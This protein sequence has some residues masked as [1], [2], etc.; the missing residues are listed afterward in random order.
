M[1]TSQSSRPDAS[2][3]PVPPPA[4][5]DSACHALSISTRAEVRALLTTSSIPSFNTARLAFP[6][7]HAVAL[8]VALLATQGT[9]YSLLHRFLTAWSTPSNPPPLPAV[10][11][12]DHTPINRPRSKWV[13]LDF[14]GN[15]HLS[16]RGASAILAACLLLPAGTLV[17]L[18]LHDCVNVSSL[19][20]RPWIPLISAQPRRA[21]L[22]GLRLDSCPLNT[23]DFDTVRS[24]PD[25]R[26]ISLRYTA[27]SNLWRCA[28]VLAA[29]PKLTAA[30]VSG[31]E[32]RRLDQMQLD[33]MRE[34][35]RKAMH[36][37]GFDAGNVAS[38]ALTSISTAL[39]RRREAMEDI[40]FSY[41][42]PQTNHPAK[43]ALLVSQQESALLRYGDRQRMARSQTVQAE[44]TL[45]AAVDLLYASHMAAMPE[46][47]PYIGRTLS[48]PVTL[49]P[50]FCDFMVAKARESFKAL[51]GIQISRQ[52]RKAAKR[53]VLESFDD[54]IVTEGRSRDLSILALMRQREDG[55][56]TSHNRARRAWT[57]SSEL[58]QKKRRR[59]TAF[60]PK[61]ADIM[62]AVAAAG[63]PR[64]APT[65]RISPS[66]SARVALTAAASEPNTDRGHNPSVLSAM[67]ISGPE[68]SSSPDSDEGTPQ[69]LL[70]SWSHAT[71][72]DQRTRRKFLRAGFREYQEQDF[73]ASMSALL[74][75]RRGAPRIQYLDHW[76]DSPRQF[77]YNPAKPSELVYGTEDG[78][79]VL[80]D[81]ETGEV[82]GSCLSGGG[83]GS[84]R[85][86]QV[87]AQTS[88]L[89]SLS[90]MYHNDHALHGGSVQSPVYGLSWLNNRS[91]MFLSG[92]NDGAIHVYNV[93]WM[94]SGE[95]GGCVY[96]CD[97][98][99]E[100]TSLHV[101]CDD[102]KFAVSGNQQHVGIFD[103]GTGRRTELMRGCHSESINV[104][105]F[106]HRNPN[107]LV[108]ASFDQFVKTWDLRESCP[109]GVRRPIYQ[110]R[111][112]TD[113]VMA[114]F[115]PD[116]SRLLVSAVD[117]EVR[118]YHAGDGKLE[119]EFN[120]PKSGA[121]VNF[122]RSYYMNDRDYIITG[123]SM[124]HVVRVYNARTGAF[125]REIDM[126]NRET[127]GS[128]RRLCVQTLR[129]NPGRKLSFSALLAANP[130]TV[131][132]VI[133]C[134]DLHRR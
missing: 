9:H 107:I 94:R 80:I 21:V 124:E 42:A 5:Y 25:L 118:Q 34:F 36:A 79:V 56:S 60:S 78:Y 29:L 105:K 59:T 76:Q 22:I 51:D 57:S 115:S 35:C 96:A 109:G 4:V 12:L 122:T 84:R 82:K 47:G 99:D 113:N 95:R 102:V 8:C 15:D 24:L 18:S 108:T 119:L 46:Q 16:P 38:H 39:D 67:E 117:N 87:I 43:A 19:T 123:S 68:G 30:L 65:G 86:G 110:T 20:L 45:S 125:F 61:V 88:D 26:W 106:A 83:M 62:A 93:N 127:V 2:S 54:V 116:D 114:C 11:F 23:L 7:A 40:P 75:R 111:S 129:A 90:S 14:S 3:T 1:A 31:K 126:D 55:V 48:A 131:K 101:A 64:V 92:S 17:E 27:F 85:T 32:S 72:S 112:R 71:S 6:D 41:L 33:D 44:A 73:E 66:S 63:F 103:L 104:T 50:R 70:D 128:V 74:V 81:Q 134:A 98:F 49:H 10:S 89:N 97:T 77:E 121:A 133:A 53:R 58:R 130:G 37:I 28:E 52:K 13:S 69:S 91:D 100:L 132:G 120:I